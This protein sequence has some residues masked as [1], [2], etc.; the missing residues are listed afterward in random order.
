LSEE[1]LHEAAREF[2]LPIV[3]IAER[4]DGHEDAEPVE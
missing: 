3:W 1:I 4:A 2:L